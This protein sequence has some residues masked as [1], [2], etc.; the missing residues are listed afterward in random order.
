MLLRRKRRSWSPVPRYGN[1]ALVVPAAHRHLCVAERA[2]QFIK[3]QTGRIRYALVL[4]QAAEQLEQRR[5]T[6]P[7]D[8]TQVGL[9]WPG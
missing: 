5:S 9:G 3:V 4:I 6:H 1:D 8:N 2:R 7:A